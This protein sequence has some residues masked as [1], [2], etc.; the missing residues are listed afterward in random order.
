MKYW[1]FW[2]SGGVSCFQWKSIPWHFSKVK[3]HS[4]SPGKSSSRKIYLKNSRNFQDDCGPCYK[5]IVEK[6]VY[7]CSWKARTERN[8]RIYLAIIVWLGLCLESHFGYISNLQKAITL[9]NP[10]AHLPP[11]DN[12][13]WTKRWLL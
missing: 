8:P 5:E 1:W 10:L 3:K 11:T 12:Q 7:R 13:N 9:L 4:V 6:N 2:T